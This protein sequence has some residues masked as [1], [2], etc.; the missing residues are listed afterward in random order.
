MSHRC[1]QAGLAHGSI[2]VRIAQVK[3]LQDCFDGSFMK[4]VLF[5]ESIGKEFIEH[6]GKLGELN[7]YPEFARPFYKIVVRGAF[8]IKGVEGNSTLRLIL[9][10]DRAQEA[11]EDFQSK[12]RSFSAAEDTQL[13]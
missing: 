5:D 1:C 6:F 7:Y 13:R 4:E 10:R 9:K 11:L 8:T 3:A 12:V 2:D